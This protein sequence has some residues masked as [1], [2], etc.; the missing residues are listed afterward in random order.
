M[1]LNITTSIQENPFLRI[2]RT[3]QKRS[4]WL[5][6]LFICIISSLPLLH[7]NSGVINPLLQQICRVTNP[8]DR[9]NQEIRF[10]ELGKRDPISIED[11][12]YKENPA[13]PQHRYVPGN[14]KICSEEKTS[15]IPKNLITFSYTGNIGCRNTGGLHVAIGDRTEN[16][17]AASG[18]VCSEEIT[19]KEKRSLQPAIDKQEREAEI[20]RSLHREEFASEEK[21]KTKTGAEIKGS[22]HLL[23]EI[24]QRQT[25]AEN[26]RNSAEKIK[27]RNAEVPNTDPSSIKTTRS[28]H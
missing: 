28:L 24:A 26:V 16:K 20:E 5:L 1:L 22:L 27:R 6:F 2:D 18:G 12:Q 8:L 11:P 25:E 4:P 19:V 10:V 23:P 13:C 21:Q 14:I 7:H 17:E 9:V 3:T 15:K